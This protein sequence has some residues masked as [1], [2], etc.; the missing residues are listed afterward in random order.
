MKNYHQ[1]KTKRVGALVLLFAFQPAVSPLARANSA[2]T[3]PAVIP[4]GPTTTVGPA[5]AVASAGV[6]G[7]RRTGRAGTLGERNLPDLRF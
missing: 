7:W 2:S 4:S 5:S 3:S 6:I 1:Y